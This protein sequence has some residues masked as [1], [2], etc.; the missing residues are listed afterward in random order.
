MQGPGPS[1]SNRHE[2]HSALLTPHDHSVNIAIF[3]DSKNQWQVHHL[4]LA[5]RCTR[6]KFCKCANM[7]VS[8]GSLVWDFFFFFF[9]LGWG[10]GLITFFYLEVY[11]R[12]FTQ[13]LK[14]KKKT[15]FSLAFDI[16]LIKIHFNKKWKVFIQRQVSKLALHF[17]IKIHYFKYLIK[18]YFKILSVTFFFHFLNG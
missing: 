11:I 9:F 3:S 12:H 16:H 17:R 13:S 15:F 14:G 6:H 8:F 2:S 1:K 4:A 5:T 18:E 10:V 7:H